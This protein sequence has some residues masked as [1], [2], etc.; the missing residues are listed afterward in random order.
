MGEE[1]LQNQ[2]MVL[3]TRDIFGSY[4]SEIISSTTVTTECSNHKELVNAQS[5]LSHI[6]G[7]I[8]SE[9]DRLG[10]GETLTI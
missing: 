10:R 3:A 6:N 1:L 7:L 5:L 4:A 8:H 9:I 2:V